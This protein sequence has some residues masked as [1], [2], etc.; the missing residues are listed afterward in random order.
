MTA[1]WPFFLFKNSHYSLL[2]THRLGMLW[3]AEKGAIRSVISMRF[4]A[5]S[6]ELTMK[7]GRKTIIPAI[8]AWNPRSHER[9]A[10]VRASK[11]GR[12]TSVRVTG[13]GGQR[14]M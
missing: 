8:I 10:A 3:M 4:D 7:N 2:L 12:L 11:S 14:Q 5:F 9:W 1:K 6:T 13:L